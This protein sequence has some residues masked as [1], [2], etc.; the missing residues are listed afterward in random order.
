MGGSRSVPLQEGGCPWS[1]R[2]LW[3]ARGR[4]CCV[5]V[6]GQSS[7]V[8]QWQLRAAWTE[9]V[10][11]LSAPQTGSH[12]SGSQS[13]D[14]HRGHYGPAAKVKG[15]GHGHS[16]W[17]SQWPCHGAR[18]QGAAPRAPQGRPR[19]VC[20]AGGRRLWRTRRGLK[21]W[22]GP[23]PAD[24]NGGLRR[25]D[26]HQLDHQAQQTQWSGLS[27]RHA[28]GRQPLPP[29]DQRPAPPLLPQLRPMPA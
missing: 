21:P 27:P 19:T 5:L 24:P 12:P 1:P 7:V 29:P 13:P 4:D 18:G 6:V 3:L 8:Q 25:R 26:Q 22:C 2:G 9:D 20:G 15:W 17:R 10:C 11:L 14:S 23:S 28:G 16:G